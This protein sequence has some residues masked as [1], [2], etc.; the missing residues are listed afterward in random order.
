MSDQMG[1]VTDMTVGQ[2][3]AALASER[4][5]PGGGAAAAVAAALAA[6]LTEMVIRLSQG[7]PRYEQHADLYVE[8]LAASEAARAR[9]LELADEDAAAYEAYRDARRLPRDTEEDVQARDAA[10]RAAA[11]DAARVPLSVV[12]ECHRHSDLVE[13]LAG[14]SNASVASDLDVA[15]LLLESASRGAAANVLVNLSAVEDESYSAA[16]TAELDQR[17][18]QIQSATARTREYVGKGV[19]RRPEPT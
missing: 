14:R 9:F 12:Q 3:A 18:R 17:L 11:R 7:R 10:T 4:P 15:A 8:A 19:Q 1:V 6:S 16:V 13:R 5:T 2:F